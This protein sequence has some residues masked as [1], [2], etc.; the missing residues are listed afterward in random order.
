MV[1]FQPSLWFDYNFHF[2]TT[3]VLNNACKSTCVFYDF[4]RGKKFATITS[5]IEAWARSMCEPILRL[6]IVMLVAM[7]NPI[8][9]CISICLSFPVFHGVTLLKSF[10]SLLFMVKSHITCKIQYN[11]FRT[12]Y[13]KWY[14]VCTLL[15]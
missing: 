4:L 7:P 15:T 14:F 11:V 6:E 2:F 1:C 10:S 8:W 3:R 13:S 12:L 9:S 5:N